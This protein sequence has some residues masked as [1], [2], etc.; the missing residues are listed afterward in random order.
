MVTNSST[1]C[2]YNHATVNIFLPF[3]G[4]I[5]D[6]WN[7]V[8]EWHVIAKTIRP[9]ESKKWNQIEPNKIN[10]TLGY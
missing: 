8:I 6:T 2:Y 10:A 9:T 4:S 7:D 5:G 1:F 3:Y